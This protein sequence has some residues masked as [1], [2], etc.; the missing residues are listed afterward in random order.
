MVK[1]IILFLLIGHCLLNKNHAWLE[2][3]LAR[4]KSATN[5]L[6][7]ITGHRRHFKILFRNKRSLMRRRH[8][9][10]GDKDGH[11][12][13]TQS[14]LPPQ[15]K[16][17]GCKLLIVNKKMISIVCLDENQYKLANS[18]VVNFFAQVPLLLLLVSC[19]SSWCYC[20]ESN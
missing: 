12:L 13:T 17:L 9:C 14:Y 4:W 19:F 6:V 5:Q 1:R 20:L 8:N 11:Q 2:V 15:Y 7:K 18:N 3:K 10:K 16:F